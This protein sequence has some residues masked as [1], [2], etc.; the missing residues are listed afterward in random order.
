VPSLRRP[1]SFLAAALA[2]VAGFA[3]NQLYHS[4]DRLPTLEGA[5]IYTLYMAHA[6]GKGGRDDVRMHVATFDLNE[7]EPSA[8]LDKCS[9]VRE[10]LQNRASPTLTFWCEP[11]RYHG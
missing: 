6:D 9:H 4:R 5:R 2:F 3:V 8:N 7:H 11:G 1:G 10:I